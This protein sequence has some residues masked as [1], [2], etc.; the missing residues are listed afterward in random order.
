MTML[1]Q[2]SSGILLHPTSFPSQHGIGDL[3]KSA[4][5]FIDFL[6]QSGYKFWQI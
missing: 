4:Y 5:E 3:G 1:F 2:R 6:Q